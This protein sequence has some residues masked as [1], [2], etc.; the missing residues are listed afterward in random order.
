MPHPFLSEV[1]KKALAFIR[2]AF[3]S[4]KP[5]TCNTLAVVLGGDENYARVY[6]RR[7]KAKALVTQQTGSRP[8]LWVP[9]DKVEK[10]RAIKEG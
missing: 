8:C 7:L 3:T 6:C 5:A 1:D 9:S 2:A 4:G 10:E